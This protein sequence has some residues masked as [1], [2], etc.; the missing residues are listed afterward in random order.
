MSG[1]GVGPETGGAFLM[2]L[3]VIVIAG[4]PYYIIFSM[5]LNNTA[6]A[7][8]AGVYFIVY[9]G[10]IGGML[11]TWGTAL[12]WLMLTLLLL[13]SIS[14]PWLLGASERRAMWKMDLED[15]A[16]CDA[17]IRRA[18]T[19][20][21]NYDR[22][23]TICRR[24]GEYARAIQYAEAYLAAVGEDFKMQRR[25]E[26]LK[27]MLRRQTLGSKICPVCDTENTPG[28]AECIRCG[29]LLALPTDVV[30]GCASETG[31]R[32]LAAT[33]ITLLAIGIA[34]ALLRSSALAIG[35][36]FVSAFVTAMTYVYLR[37]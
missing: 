8:E 13:L 20:V 21:D 4:Y 31:L 28:A 1:E 37:R 34:L 5:L 32:A 29:R 12:S 17:F 22:A 25:L 18:P 9:T 15:L 3:V 23:I 35:I 7:T 24:R 26:Q 10:F 19:I 27:R 30:A 33:T 36:V 16:E 6:S 11:A 14:Y 2:A